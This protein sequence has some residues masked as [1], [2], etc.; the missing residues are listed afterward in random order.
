MF[1]GGKK[2]SKA[3]E[4]IR[5]HLNKVEE[6]LESLDTSLKNYLEGNFETADDLAYK[7]HV[8]ESKADDRRREIIQVLYE[9][10]FL[11]IYR[12]GLIA[13]TSKVDKVADHAESISDFMICQ[14]P[15]IPE[16]LKSSFLKLA[17]NSLACFPPLK[18][19]IL[20]LF[21][22]ASIIKKR[23]EEINEQ[24]SS[25]DKDEW[26]MT[27]K[28]FQSDISLAQKIHISHFLWRVAGISDI[29]QDAADRLQSLMVNI[30]F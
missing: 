9:G 29:C 18:E 27:Q 22:D 19:A 21:T 28:I 12:E 30:Q 16:D 15:E 3:K 20:N 24:E 8:K 5:E 7:I 26:N 25:V 13:L 1:G 6:C 2:E 4:L 10:A 14:T 11:P 17:E 23:I